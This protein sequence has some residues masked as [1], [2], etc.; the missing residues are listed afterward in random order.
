MTG[1]FWLDLTNFLLGMGTLVLAGGIAFS[2]LQEFWARRHN[3]PPPR[4]R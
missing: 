3:P 4:M 1:T 2:A